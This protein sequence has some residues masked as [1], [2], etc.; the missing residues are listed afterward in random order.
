MRK[1]IVAALGAGV[2]LVAG[3]GSDEGSTSGTTAAG[4]T[5]DQVQ[6]D[7]TLYKVGAPVSN[8]GVTVTVR[9]AASVPAVAMASGS[10]EYADQAA[11]AGE[12]YEVIDAVVR[13][14]AATPMDLSCGKAIGTRLVDEQRRQFDAIASLDRVQG[15]PACAVTLPQGSESEMKWVFAVPVDAVPRAFGFYDTVIQQPSQVKVIDLKTQ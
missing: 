1:M 14:D 13:N 8:G 10:G 12:K 5:S 4:P 7:L 3:C 9:S 11:P 15:N 6:P 2:L